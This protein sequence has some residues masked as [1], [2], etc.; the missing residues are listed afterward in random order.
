MEEIVV[1][2]FRFRPNI[3]AII[4]PTIAKTADFQKTFFNFPQ[5]SANFSEIPP[6]RT[7]NPRFFLPAQE[8]KPRILHFFA[9]DLLNLLFQI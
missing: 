7:K 4:V 6:G 5:I 3:Q 2:A 9:E 8:E 1:S